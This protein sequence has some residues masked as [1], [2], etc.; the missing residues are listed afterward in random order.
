MIEARRFGSAWQGNVHLVR[1][2]RCKFVEGQRGDKADD[3]HRDL[4]GHGDQIGVPQRR[5]IGKAVKATAEAREN[6]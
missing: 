2:L 1:N 3:A 4:H 5:Q 6:P